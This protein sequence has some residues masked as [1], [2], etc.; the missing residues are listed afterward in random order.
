MA[1]RRALAA[2]GMFECQ[3]IKLI[4][5]AHCLML[6]DDQRDALSMAGGNRPAQCFEK[7]NRAF[8]E[9]LRLV[10]SPINVDPQ[11]ICLGLAIV[12]KGCSR[13]SRAFRNVVNGGSAIALFEEKFCCCVFECCDGG[14]LGSAPFSSCHPVPYS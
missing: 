11:Y 6:S 12:E 2:L 4:A 14:G 9:A 3:T 1:L 13:D 10:E 5:D 8:S 7:G